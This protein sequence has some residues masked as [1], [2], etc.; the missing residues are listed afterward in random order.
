MCGIN[1]VRST[2][3]SS[4]HWIR[5]QGTVCAA[6]TS[7]NI[8]HSSFYYLLPVVLPLGS[9]C[10]ALFYWNPNPITGRVRVSVKS[11]GAI[12]TYYLRCYLCI[13]LFICFLFSFCSHMLRLVYMS[14]IHS[15][16]AECCILVFRFLPS[17]R[18]LE[19]VPILS[20]S[21][22]TLFF[23]DVWKSQCTT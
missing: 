7:T 20:G 10:G 9:Y 6:P 17:I 23:R 12:T 22:E 8:M 11:C 5:R 13:L 15:H 16:R 4:L 1:D 3:R 14:S 21:L 2:M 19:S 18:R